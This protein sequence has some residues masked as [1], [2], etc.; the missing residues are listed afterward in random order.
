MMEVLPSV[1]LDSVL[2]IICL[3]FMV[4]MW[5]SYGI[6]LLLRLFSTFFSFCHIHICVCNHDDP[7]HMVPK[8]NLIWF[9]ITTL[10]QQLALNRYWII[11]FFII[12]SHVRH[13]YDSF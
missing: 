5:F 6:I 9:S 7:V 10:M 2:C 12:L 3:L 4:V 13:Y 11:D 8:V 1:G